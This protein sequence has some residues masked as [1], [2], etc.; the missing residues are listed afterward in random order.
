MDQ[1][2]NSTGSAAASPLSFPAAVPVW[3][4]AVVPS[5]PVPPDELPDPPQPVSILPTIPAQTSKL[6]NLFFMLLF[7]FC[8]I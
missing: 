5:F 3:T 8:F 1:K 2:V 4:A 7:S 6:N